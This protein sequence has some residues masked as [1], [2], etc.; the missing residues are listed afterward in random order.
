MAHPFEL[1]QELELDAT[2]EQVWEAIAT[3]PGIDSW[4]MGRNDI[5]PRVGGTTRS[6]MGGHTETSTVTAWEPP[7][8]FAHRTPEAP[9]GQFMAFEYLIEGRGQGSTLLRLV[10]SGFLGDDWEAEYDALRKGW[11]LHLR[12]LAAYLTHFSG[13]TGT[14]IFAPAPAQ[15][16]DVVAWDGLLRGLALDEPVT[17]GDRVRFSLDDTRRID[18]VVDSVRR[19]GFLGVRTDDALYRFL[20]RGGFLFVNHHVFTDIDRAAEETAWEAWLA[21]LFA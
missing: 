6:A 9:D 14:A 1:H 17:E 13:R 4:F 11:P 2:P 15:P 8:R 21:R 19:P 5:E 7:T 18:G 10:H 16:D 3:G 20:G 12:T